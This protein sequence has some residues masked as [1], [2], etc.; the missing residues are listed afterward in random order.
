MTRQIF[1]SFDTKDEAIKTVDG[2]ELKG[3]KAKNITI[4]ANNDDTNDLAL[5]TD[6][7]VESSIVETDSDPSFVDK[8]KKVFTNDAGSHPYLHDKLIHSGISDK[9]ASKY[10]DEIESGKILV[11]ADDEMRMGNDSVSDDV[12]LEVDTIRRD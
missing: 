1:G 5:R 4:F 12:T 10:V 11:I 2:L 8:V 7:N 3:Y 6:V 9:Q